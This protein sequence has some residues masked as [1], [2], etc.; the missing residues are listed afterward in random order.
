MELDIVSEKVEV[1]ETAPGVTTE[2]AAAPPATVTKTELI[3]IPTPQ[4]KVKDVIPFT[5]GVIRLSIANYVQG[6][7]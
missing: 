4:E 1:N 7:G 6:L 2:S 3:T 5:P